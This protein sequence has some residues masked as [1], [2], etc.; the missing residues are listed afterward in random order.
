MTITLAEHSQGE[1]W[2][3]MDTCVCGATDKPNPDCERCMLIAEIKR[4]REALEKIAEECE[5]CEVRITNGAV[6]YYFNGY[7]RCLNNLLYDVNWMGNIYDGEKFARS[8]FI[9][10]RSDDGYL[11]NEE[12]ENSVSE[13]PEFV[14]MRTE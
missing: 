11:F 13:R 14:R 8:A 3:V 1:G 7:W 9:M 6:Q 4:L 12:V 2:R 10:W 5:D